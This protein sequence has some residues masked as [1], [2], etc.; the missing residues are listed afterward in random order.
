MKTADELFERATI[1]LGI[2][3][4]VGERK[5]EFAMSFSDFTSALA[6]HDKEIISLIESHRVIQTEPMGVKTTQMEINSVLYDI[7][8]ELET[9]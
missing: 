8:K 1:S 3:S 6:E 5:D 7:I 2:H 4:T 9:K